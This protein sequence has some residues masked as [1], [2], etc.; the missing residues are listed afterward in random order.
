MGA[1]YLVRLDDA[2]PTM[3]RERWI[4]VENL[5][6]RHGIRPIV[7]VVPENR[8]RGLEIDSPDGSFWDKAR[9]WR[10]KGWQI[11]LHG[12]TH[13]YTTNCPG[14]VPINRQSEFAGV[15]S[16]VQRR[17]LR[18]GREIFE[19]QSLPVSLWVAPSHS[20]DEV[21][22]FALQEETPIRVISDGLALWPFTA[23]GFTWIPQQLWGPRKMHGGVWT[24][25]LH[26][27]TISD[28]LLSR[29]EDHMSVSAEGYRKSVEDL[30]RQ[31]AG[32]K[33]SWADKTF[34]CWFMLR[35]RWRDHLRAG[36]IWFNARN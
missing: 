32:R 1:T 13:E 14:L 17:K 27:N 33:A 18:R 3:S 15:A 12:C 23:K 31:Y 6:D 16:E 10:D 30:V 5:L 7:A 9:T 25:C 20:F 19:R 34:H 22:L 29:L 24:I 4:A 26:P 28:S 35:R 36:S 8:D 21:T 2:C 11:A